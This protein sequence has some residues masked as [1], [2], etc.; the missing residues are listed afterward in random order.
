MKHLKSTQN[1]IQT[2][3]KCNCRVVESTGDMVTNVKVGDVVIPTFIGECQECENCISEESNIC[4]KY[5]VT[6]NGLMLDNTSRMSIRGQRIFHMFTCA[7]WC[8]YMVVE[9][10]YLVKVDPTIDLAHASFISCGFST[11]F[12]AAW[13]EAKVQTGSSLAVFGLGAVGLGVCYALFLI[14]ILLFSLIL[15]S[16]NCL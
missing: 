5:S 4:L 12:G 13:K 8:E 6:Y 15:Q 14:F 3:Y 11:G 1:L 10:N 7:T 9:A 16:L 2:T